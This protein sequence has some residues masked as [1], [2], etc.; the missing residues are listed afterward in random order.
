MSEGVGKGAK[1]VYVDGEE[2]EAFTARL[3]TADDWS[4]SMGRLEDL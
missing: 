4:V 2:T 1:D 3:T